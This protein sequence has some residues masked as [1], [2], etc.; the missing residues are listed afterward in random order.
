MIRSFADETT[1]DLFADIN[2]RAAR[3]IPR[4]LWRIA[5]RKLKQIDLAAQLSDT[6]TF[7]RPTGWRR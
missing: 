4:T 5:Q 6:W 2:S 3:R 1:R 7:R